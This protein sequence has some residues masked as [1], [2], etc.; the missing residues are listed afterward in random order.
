MGV[1]APRN[2]LSTDSPSGTALLIAAL[3]VPVV[4]Q[5]LLLPGS[6][7]WLWVA[8]G[9]VAFAVAIGPVAASSLGERVGAWFRGIGVEGRILALVAVVAAVWLVTEVVEGA[10][11]PLHS[12]G[13]G[14]LLAVVVFVTV[15]TVYARIAG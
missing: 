15:R 2:W 9:F 12:I 14:G 7:A 1:I 8:V 3:A 13:T 6:L 5:N 11:T 4:V 10:F